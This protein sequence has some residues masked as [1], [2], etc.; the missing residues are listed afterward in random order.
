MPK[1]HQALDQLVGQH[2]LAFDPVVCALHKKLLDPD[3]GWFEQLPNNL[4]NKSNGATHPVLLHKD[5]RRLD[6]RH[7][8]SS[9]QLK[10]G[11]QA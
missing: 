8:D 1:E 3:R 10:V 9:L 4:R 7:S 11:A 6:H 2:H 5:Y